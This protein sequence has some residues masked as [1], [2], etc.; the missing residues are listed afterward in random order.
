[1]VCWLARFSQ[2]LPTLPKDDREHRERTHGSA[3]TSRLPLTRQPRATGSVTDR[4]R[5]ASPWHRQPG[6]R[7]LSPC[8]AL[9]SEARIGMTT[10]EYTAKMTPDGRHQRLLSADE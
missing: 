9:L 10:S 1:M 7:F 2:R 5:P 4:S 8:H 3:T 6:P